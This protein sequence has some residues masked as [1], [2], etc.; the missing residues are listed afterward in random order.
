MD[1]LHLLRA[2]DSLGSS[3]LPKETH[4]EVQELRRRRRDLSERLERSTLECLHLQSEIKQI[5]KREEQ[6]VDEVLQHTKVQDMPSTVPCKVE[7]QTWTSN[8]TYE[9]VSAPSAHWQQVVS[10]SD[11]SGGSGFD[12]ISA[13]RWQPP[14]QMF[15]SHNDEGHGTPNAM[16]PDMVDDIKLALSA[17]TATSS[18]SVNKK[19]ASAGTTADGSTQ[20]KVK[21]L[22]GIS[23]EELR[24]HVT[25]IGHL[26]DET[27]GD[28]KYPV[29]GRAKKE[30][31]YNSVRHLL[32]HL[33]DKT[34]HPYK[35]PVEGCDTSSVRIDDV[36]KHVV[37][38]HKLEWNDDRKT[39]SIDA[40][41]K[42]LVDSLMKERK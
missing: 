16:H 41:K 12:A 29:C 28:F 34:Y 31:K 9:E 40:E 3:R 10:S 39:A 11:F 14:E 7:T 1:F 27:T 35:C 5:Q 13:E 36:Q 33:N 15:D 38:V 42:T 22:N 4:L 30:S 26:C 6:L 2:N 23:F 18:A 37:N 24:E 32:G 21:K 17:E 19:R 8:S 20:M 25:N